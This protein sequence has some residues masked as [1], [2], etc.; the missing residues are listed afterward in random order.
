[1]SK[2]P[3]LES[4]IS[5]RDVLRA[6]ALL[7]AS[8]VF[9]GVRIVAQK[10]PIKLGVI[11]PFSG[12]Y[13]K[14]GEEAM[15]GMT[16][17]LDSVGSKFGGR[18]VQ[19]IREDEEAS[20][21]AAL[22]KATKLIQQDKIDVLAGINL[23]P[24]AYAIRDLVHSSQTPWVCAVA[25]GNLLTRARKSPYIFR[26]SFT[27]WQSH[28]PFGRWVAQSGIKRVMI[29]S[30]DAAFGREA[31]AGFKEGFTAAGGQIVEEVYTPFPSQDFSPYI[32]RIAAAKPDAVF[33]FLAGSD[34]VIFL[35]QFAQFGLN[36][37]IKLTV[38]GELTDET[39]LEAVGDAG[40][41]VRSSAPW[42]YTLPNS[43][44]LQFVRNYRAKFKDVPNLY[45]ER[46]FTAA[47][48]VGEA[49]RATKG[50][51]N[52]QVLLAALKAVR[53]TAPRGP[54]EF[55]PVTQ[56]VIQ[57]VYVR[58]VVKTNDGFV[59]KFIATLGKVQDPAS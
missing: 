50:E 41:K 5:R 56:H 36:K 9:G 22:R 46:G 11:L 49:L 2:P 37:T 24:S 47:R 54:I 26:T 40:L 6:G 1:M 17:Y 53:F 23:T 19:V 51:P 25:G 13:T 43:E 39:V 35:R 42:A 44:N 34:G 7:A 29:V 14:L 4:S 33:S 48:V 32:A 55:D 45:A 15:R 10:A 38:S 12:P 30:A 21:D 16:M 59:N 20:P 52:P 58:E 3:K 57:S 31:S 8:S 18:A 27:M 28:Q